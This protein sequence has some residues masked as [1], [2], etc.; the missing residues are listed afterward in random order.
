MNSSGPAL[1]VRRLWLFIMNAM[2]S[3]FPE[4]GDRHEPAA[5]RPDRHVERGADAEML[6]AE[7]DQGGAMPPPKTSLIPTTSPEAVDMSFAGTASALTGPIVRTIEVACDERRYSPGKRKC[8]GD[9]TEIPI[10]EVQFLRQ[11]RREW[12]DQETID[13]H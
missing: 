1:V 10:V 7:A 6:G 2:G 5:K 11:Q 12:D 3:G 13:A 4:E 9:V 8:T